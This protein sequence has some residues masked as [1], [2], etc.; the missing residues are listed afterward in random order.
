MELITKLSG[1][2]KPITHTIRVALNHT[3]KTGCDSF[4]GII[5]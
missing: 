1:L 5:L 4:S 3:P 2:Q